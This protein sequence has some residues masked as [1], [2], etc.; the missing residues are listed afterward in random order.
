LHPHL[1]RHRHCIHPDVAL[2]VRSSSSPHSWFLGKDFFFFFFFSSV[3]FVW[4]MEVLLGFAARRCLGGRS[5]AARA[6]LQRVSRP[7]I[8]AARS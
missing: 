5:A 8:A 4:A 3:L 7:G 1:H 6:L 2:L